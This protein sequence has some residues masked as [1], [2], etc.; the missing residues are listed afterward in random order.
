M[1][2][3]SAPVL[4]I[5]TGPSG[6][7]KSTVLAQLRDEFDFPSH[8]IVD[9][10]KSPDEVIEAIENALANQQDI[11]VETA[12][13]RPEILALMEQATDEGFDVELIIIGIEHIEI[14]KDRLKHR[15]ID[16]TV[17]ADMHEKTMQHLPAAYDRAKRVLIIDN[18]AGAPSIALQMSNGLALHQSAEQPTFVQRLL[19][20]KVER[21][22]SKQ[23]IHKAFTLLDNTSH[24]KPVLQAA[25]VIAPAQF[26][27]VILEK[28]EHHVLQQVSQALHLVHDIALMPYGGM[29][30]VKGAIATI[31]YHAP[32][33]TTIAPQIERTID[34]SLSR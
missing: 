34:K 3:T 12:L 14:A 1:T 20:A 11:A 22:L 26:T 2:T 13:L 24:L 16:D 30:L 28:T 18:S 10:D 23:M 33:A 8:L 25:K 31:A 29:S 19:Q 15:A 4:T 21:D 17:L 7:G 9:N 32:K 5:L 6:A 27:G